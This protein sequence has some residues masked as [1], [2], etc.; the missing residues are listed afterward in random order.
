MSKRSVGRWSNPR[1]PYT[2]SSLFR[3]RKGTA[4]FPASARRIAGAHAEP[5]LLIRTPSSPAAWVT[6]G[7]M[8]ATL[9]DMVEDL[10]RV[11]ANNEETR[12]LI[13]GRPALGDA[14]ADA[15]GFLRETL[16]D[17]QLTLSSHNN[18][19][20]FPRIVLSAAIAD[21][22]DPFWARHGDVV[23]WWLARHHDVTDDILLAVRPGSTHAAPQ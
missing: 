2:S 22:G 6:S 13:A 11:D 10:V 14:L 4:T 9:P 3:Y 17:A 1:I 8:D 7:A 5:F 21:R 23:D 16:P 15:I 12:R 19:P 18:E 20:G